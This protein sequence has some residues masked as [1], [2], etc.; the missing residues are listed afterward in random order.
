MLQR[1]I[2]LRDAVIVLKPWDNKRNILAYQ[3]RKPVTEIHQ[4]HPSTAASH[5]KRSEGW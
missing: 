2:S 5:G 3:G 1:S 4:Q